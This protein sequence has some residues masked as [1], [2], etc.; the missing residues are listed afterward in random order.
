[1][2]LTVTPNPTNGDYFEKIKR[3]PLDN[4]MD[5]AGSLGKASRRDVYS[6]IEAA[7]GVPSL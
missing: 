2:R 5:K 4:K 1:M 6:H 3:L 7:K